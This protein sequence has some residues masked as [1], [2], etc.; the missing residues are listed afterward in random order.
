MLKR[1]LLREMVVNLLK[2]KTLAGDK[3]YNSL[4]F[5]VNEDDCPCILVYSPTD[6]GTSRARHI[7]L[8]EASLTINI[9]ARVMQE[10]TGAA[11]ALDTL[12]E[13]IETIILSSQA[14]QNEIE[15]VSS[16]NTQIGVDD[17]GKTIFCVAIL[18]ITVDY[19]REYPTVIDDQF[20]AA[21][22]NTDTIDPYDPNRASKGPD[23]RIEATADVL[24]PQN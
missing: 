6:N 18:G 8:M 16:V 15:G 19:R 10:Y 14:F 21:T 4:P 12:A 3:V 20:L 7:P 1:T 17:G 13:Q 5:N 2:N 22:I 11:L 23:G 9:E 24:I